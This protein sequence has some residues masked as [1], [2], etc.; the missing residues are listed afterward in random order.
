METGEAHHLSAHLNGRAGPSPGWEPGP[1][2]D[3][4]G[5]ASGSPYPVQ[6]L[7]PQVRASQ[8][9]WGPPS[10]LRQECYISFV[11]HGEIPLFSLG[12]EDVACWEE[13][14]TVISRLA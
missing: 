10:F 4:D 11:N 14:W 8:P 9:A 5:R 3:A 7:T 13:H 12:Y 6:L 2:A 1:G